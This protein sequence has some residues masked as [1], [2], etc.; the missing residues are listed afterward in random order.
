MRD[1]GVVPLIN[2]VFLLL[3]FFMV[4]GR[5]MASDPFPIEPPESASEG[6]AAE[7]RLVALGP[8]GELALDGVVMGETQLLSALRDDLAEA[9]PPEIRIKADGEAQAMVLV[10][11]LGRLRE[12]GAESVMLMT[13]PEG[14]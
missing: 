4:T 1:E 14:M 8:G 9:A 6:P 5:L 2:I 3:V 10:A 11:L 13:V 12:I 7:G